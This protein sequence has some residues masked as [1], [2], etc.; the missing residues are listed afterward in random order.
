MAEQ[1]RAAARGGAAWVQLR[2]K[3]ASDADLAALVRQL[4]PEMEALG[5][6]LIVNDRIEV[7]LATGAHGLHIGQGDGDAAIVRRRMPADMILG[8]SVETVAQARRIPPGVDYIGA[9]PVRATSTKPDHAT[10][11]GFDGLAQIVAAAAMPTFAIGGLKPGD[12]RAVRAAG[13]IGMAVVSA[14]TRAPDPEA[15]TRAVLAEWRSA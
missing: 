10:P 1:A 12:A 3:T 9:G 13:A 15:A 5:A 7:A 14:V 8:L 2:D 4:L 11:I 6:R